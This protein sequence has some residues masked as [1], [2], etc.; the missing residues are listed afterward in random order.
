[1]CTCVRIP[2]HIQASLNLCNDTNR[3]ERTVRLVCLERGGRGQAVVSRFVQGEWRG[4]VVMIV[5]EGAGGMV[6]FLGAWEMLWFG[7]LLHIHIPP[8]TITSIDRTPNFSQLL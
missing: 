8:S 7:S 6:D 3:D 4:I 1:M 5:V 2:G